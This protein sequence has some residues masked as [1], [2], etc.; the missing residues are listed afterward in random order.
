MEDLKLAILID[1][2]N[3]SP[4]YVK[5]ILDEAATFGVAACKRIYGDWSDVRLKS[6]KDALLNNSIIPIQQYSYTTGKNATDSAMIIDA[7]DLLY[8]GNLDGFCIVSSDSDFTRLAARLR[9]AGKLVIGMGESKALGPFVKACD[10]F[11]Y[12]DL[13]LDHGE[14]DDTAPAA[15]AAEAAARANAGDDTAINRDSI[16]RII[17]G[18]ID[19]MDDGTGWVRTSRVGDQLIKRYPDFDVRNFGSKSL[20]KFLASLPELEV[21]ERILANGNPIQFVRVKPLPKPAKKPTARRPAAKRTTRKKKYGRDSSLPSD[22]RKRC[23]HPLAPSAR[24]LR[25]QAVGER[26][27]RLPDANRPPQSNSPG[28]IACPGHF[29]FNVPKPENP[30]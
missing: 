26:T 13:I 28:H 5:V 18:L 20:N 4:K 23:V 12:L 25:P 2:D 9:E 30:D 3:I 15:P 29:H 14:T 21:E 27:V 6:W 17:H 24:G 8:G 7:M 22:C 11:K 1:A 10:Q 19:E 16:G